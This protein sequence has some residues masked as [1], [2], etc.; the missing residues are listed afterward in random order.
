MNETLGC[1]EKTEEELSLIK[2]CHNS[3]WGLSQSAAFHPLFPPHGSGC[4]FSMISIRL[5]EKWWGRGERSSLQQAGEKKMSSPVT[6]TSTSRWEKMAKGWDICFSLLTDLFVMREWRGWES[7]E[8]WLHCVWGAAVTQ[9]AAQP[10]LLS[11]LH[12][13]QWESDLQ[14]AKSTTRSPHLCS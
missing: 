2:K 7:G 3:V 14:A 10:N 13:G 5:F 1:T 11:Q 12:C 4:Y 6:L 9:E 8:K